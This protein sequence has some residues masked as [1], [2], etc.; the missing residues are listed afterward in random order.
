MKKVLVLYY[1]QSGQLKRVI[2][3]FIKDLPDNE[4][5]VDLKEINPKTLY[6]Y[7]WPFYKFAAEFPEAVL[8]EG[9][10]IEDIDNL[11]DD[12]NLIILGYTIWFLSPA[13]PIVAFLRSKQAKELFKDKPVVTVIACRDMWVMAQEKMKTLLDA[14]GAKL[15]DNVALTDQ[16]KGIYSFVTTPRWLLSGKKDAFWF[17]PPAGILEEDIAEAKRFGKRINEALKQDKEKEFK[18]LLQ[19]LGAVSVNGKLIASEVIATRSSKIWAKLI[20]KFGTKDS[21]GRKVGV[22]IYSVFLVILVFTV[23]PLNIAVRKILN[24]FQK[25]KL[26]ALEIKYEQP[27]GK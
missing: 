15:I 13:P 4:I 22:T 6:P 2:D 14:V 26:K 5:K 25:E 16:G 18:P 20:K 8:M 21:F 24:I 3:S 12:Y 23:V 10:E 19:G 11:E 17:F 7:P 1:S 9:C 27:S